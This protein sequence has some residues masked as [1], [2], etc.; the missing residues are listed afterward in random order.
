MLRALFIILVVII[1]FVS[2]SLIV[3]VFARGIS[4]SSFDKSINASIHAVLYGFIAAVISVVPVA[5]FTE[6]TEQTLGIVFPIFILTGF[7]TIVIKLGI[8]YA[9]FLLLIPA[10]LL[11]R[12]ALLFLGVSK[13]VPNGHYLEYWSLYSLWYPL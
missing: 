12:E 5:I 6:R 9:R 7:I 13:L 2:L 11:F 4:K 8:S 3:A 10:L 1:V